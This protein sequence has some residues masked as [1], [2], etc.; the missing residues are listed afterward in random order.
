MLNT[1][2]PNR[3][4]LNSGGN[5]NRVISE[6]TRKKMSKAQSGKNNPMYG[7]TMSDKTKEK[8]RQ[9]NIGR[10]I[11]DEWKE[12]IGKANIGRKHTDESNEKNRQAHLGKKLSDEIIE[13]RKYSEQK[14]IRQLLY[15]KTFGGHFRIEDISINYVHKNKSK[16][17]NF[18]TNGY[19]KSIQMAF[20][21]KFTKNDYFNNIK[22][23]HSNYNKIHNNTNI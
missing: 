22:E 21:L 16:S 10:I 3:Y 4:N 15:K 18:N 17:F 2:A 19:V 20:D 14:K 11:T 6:E 23:F 7:K 9:A 12:K 8:L 1:M 13:K 5:F